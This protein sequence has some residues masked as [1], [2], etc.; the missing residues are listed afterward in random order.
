MSD[1]DQAAMSAGLTGGP[2]ILEPKRIKV[3]GVMHIVFGG[4]GLLMSVGSVVMMQF[5]RAILEKTQSASAPGM[6]EY[7]RVSLDLMEKM[8]PMTYLGLVFTVI[9][10][11]LLLVAGINLVKSRAKGVKLSN[12]YTY[13]SLA[14]KFVGL[15]LFFVMTKPIVDELIDPLMTDADTLMKTQL[16]VLK[17][18][19]LA[20]G[21]LTPVI[22]A[23]YP[24]LV[25]ALLNKP[26]VK[27]FFAAQ[28]Q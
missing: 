8:K 27:R 18:T 26:I 23:I 1:V 14:L 11:S 10:G 12:I 25:L 21:V 20:T 22:G 3:F 17:Y 6:E 7:N 4:L 24:I 2:P 19:Q 28:G 9:L 16:N 13:V 15:I 5:Q